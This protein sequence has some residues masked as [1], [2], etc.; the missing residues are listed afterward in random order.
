MHRH[1]VDQ[2]GGLDDAQFTASIALA[3][4][5]PRPNRLFV[6]VIGFNVAGLVGVLATLVGTLLPSTV[7]AL[8]VARFGEAVR[9][10][11]S[12]RV[13]TAGLA[14]LTIGLL[15]STGWILLEPLGTRAPSWA[16]V[17]PSRLVMLRT[18]A[19][20]LWLVAAGAMDW[21]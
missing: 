8:I 13:F 15:L 7:L 3:Q 16:L 12:A 1:V 5:A 9:Q 20:P 6:A 2:R 10:H 4:A 18:K 17:A 19:S 11:R 14:S 21:V